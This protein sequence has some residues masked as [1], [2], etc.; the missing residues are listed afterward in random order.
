VTAPVPPLRFASMADLLRVRAAQQPDDTAY[1]YLPDRGGAPVALTFAQLNGR[2]RALA[3]AL[4]ERGQQ[5]ERALLLFPPG[6]DFIVAFF[7]CLI[8]RIIA[9]PMMIPRR[10]SS[11]DASDAIVKDCRPRLAVTTRDVVTGARAEIVERFRDIDLQWVILDPD[12]EPPPSADLPA[13]G[14]AAADIAFLQYTSGST[15]APKGVI[16]THANLL[17]NLEMMHLSFANA[18]QSTY[19]SWLPHYHDMGLIGVLLQSLY[20]GSLCALLATITFMRRPLSWLHAIHEYRG[21]I[22]GAPNFAFD[23]CVSRFR[24]EEMRGIDLSSWRLAVSSAEPVRAET[25]ERFAATF[26]AYG[27][28]RRAFYP[29]FGMAE[30]TVLIS[31]ERH[32]TGPAMRAVSRTALQR[33]ARIAPATEGDRSVLVGCGRELEG[34]RIAIVDPQTR[35]SLAPCRIGEIWVAGANIAQ[36]YWHNPEATAAVFNASLAGTDQA[37]WLRSG[38]LGF[39]DERG[40]LY[41]T[42]RIKD[43]MII[44]GVNYYPQDI[45]HTAQASHPALRRDA[46]AAFTVIDD[47]EEKLVVVQEVAREYRHEADLDDIVACVREAIVR[48][49][50]VAVHR[51]LLLRPNALPKTTSGKIQRNLTRQLWLEGSLPVLG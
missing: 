37:R 15:A 48:E 17:A 26:G 1:I 2:A 25:I 13:D 12:D 43:V 9:V 33:D 50:D 36:G 44:R 23:L 39:L 24:P 8:A 22:A 20:A 21:E 7:A 19:V 41:I 14:P 30:A 35:Q 28:D 34:E 29:A 32:D 27:F 31:G 46:G 4:A 47:A 49:H 40:E 6:L 51:V 18:R 38:D 16:L 45:E 11:R 3:R 42:G 10:Y 5:G